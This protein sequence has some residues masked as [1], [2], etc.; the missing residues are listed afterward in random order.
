MTI[1]TSRFTRASRSI[2]TAVLLVVAAALLG[3]CGS[4]DD[5]ATSADSL[6]MADQWVK[7]APAG[8]MTAAFGTLSNSSDTDIRIVSASSP[9]AGRMELHEVVA[10][11][12]GAMTMRQKEGG[13]VIPARGTLTLAPGGDHLMFFDLPQA[14]TP[15]QDVSVELR[16][17]D[18]S[19]TSFTAQ[20]RDFPG[21]D[22]KYSPGHGGD[23]PAPSTSE[24]SGA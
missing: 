9:A 18:G 10:S 6:T 23:S 5:D 8:E 24:Q 3:A 19:T 15:G 21:A 2:V 1:S 12:S 16:L 14:I 13:L 11:E 4:S 22:E 17:S 7:G 20:A